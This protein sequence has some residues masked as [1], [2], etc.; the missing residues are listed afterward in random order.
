V[1]TFGAGVTN[2]LIPFADE[3]VICPND[4]K[5]LP[6]FYLCG[7]NDFRSIVT[8]ITDTTSMIWE[9]L[10]ESSCPAVANSDCANENSACSWNEVGTGPD[11]TINT[12]GEFR[13][14]LNYDGGCFNQFYFNVYQNL[15][16]PNVTTR[17]IYCDTL[18]EIAVGGVPSGYEYSLDG[19]SYQ[20]S[21]IFSIA[22]PGQYTVYVRQIGVTSNPCVF[23]VPDILIR[24][25]DFTVST[26]V[27]QPLCYDDFGSIYIAANDVRPQYFF[28]ISQGATL[29]NS[30]GPI[31]E[32]NFTFQNLSPGIYTV[33]VTTED[34]CTHT[35]D[36][37]IIQPPTLEV[38]AAI[39][40]PLNCT[41]GEITIY[42]NG[43][44][45]PYFYFVNSSVDFQT[46]PTF[47]VTSSGTYELR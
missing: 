7:A 31:T 19:V 45:A 9:Q 30:V 37:E 3:V 12:S 28:E 15:L 40:E 17:D 16:D 24:D 21:P 41:D 43:G 8:G 20:A 23:T 35:E 42:A 27:E 34:G 2:P 38:T 29:V 33:T 22:T 46:V 32:N 39:T 47:T 10:D 26:I 18:G 25:R 44:T 13:L 5:Q 4:G 36:I 14:T 1:I 11:F 6:N